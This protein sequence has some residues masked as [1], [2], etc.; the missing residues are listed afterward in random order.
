MEK[1]AKVRKQSAGIKSQISMLLFAL[2]EPKLRKAAFKALWHTTPFAAGTPRAAGASLQKHDRPR[3]WS[4]LQKLTYEVMSELNTDSTM[5]FINLGYAG[6]ETPH[7][8]TLS[9]ENEDNR[10]ATQLYDYLF[11]FCDAK[12]KDVLEV[13]CGRGGGAG[14]LFKTYQPGSYLGIDFAN[15]NI[16]FCNRVHSENGLRFEVGR[17]ESLAVPDC[18]KDIIINVESSHCY[19]SPGLFFKEVHRILKPG[20]MF[21]FADIRGN[22]VAK[23]YQTVSMLEDQFKALEDMS[24]VDRTNITQNVMR[25]LEL[26][27]ETQVK[28]WTNSM[29][30]N[31]RKN[32]KSERFI[33][34][35][36]EPM[37]RMSFSTEVP[38]SAMSWYAFFKKGKA[39]Y[40]SYV[41]RKN[42]SQA[43]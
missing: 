23:S 6:L 10:Y 5:T 35:V 43:A 13:G 24:L 21:L 18:S 1:T 9:E 34:Q 30:E 7:T 19:T 17:A 38:E 12:G 15:A 31:L 32:S 14:F 22:G 3:K 25:A 20:G 42:D 40:W 41:F 4:L 8:V 33:E 37:A 36:F 39:E 29:R 27:G 11:K 16:A 28:N 2:S 26:A